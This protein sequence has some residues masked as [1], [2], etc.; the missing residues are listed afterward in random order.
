MKRNIPNQ[1][2]KKGDWCNLALGQDHPKGFPWLFFS[3]GHSPCWQ[4]QP[5]LTWL[6][7]V[8]NWLDST[9]SAVTQQAWPA[10]HSKETTRC[11]SENSTTSILAS[12]EMEQKCVWRAKQLRARC[13]FLWFIVWRVSVQR[14]WSPML[15]APPLASHSQKG[16]VGGCSRATLCPKC[17]KWG[18]SSDS[19]PKHPNYMST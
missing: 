14:N 11:R 2:H 6:S 17:A 9:Y 8:H 5:W 4:R 10:L 18:Q 16:T 13:S 19:F 7:T 12:A 15:C 3:M 1:G